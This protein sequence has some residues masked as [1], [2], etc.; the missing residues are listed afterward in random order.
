LP[1]QSNVA[2]AAP[3]YAAHEGFDVTII[4]QNIDVR[5]DFICF[6]KESRGPIERILVDFAKVLASGV[7]DE[8]ISVNASKHLF[9]VTLATKKNQ[10]EGV[11]DQIYS[12]L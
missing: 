8:V 6:R 5:S 7:I 12:V 1:A 2:Q 11:N 3:R 4:W 9:C 10:D